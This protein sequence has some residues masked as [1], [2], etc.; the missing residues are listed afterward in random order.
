MSERSR[1][2]A[3]I[4]RYDPEGLLAIGAPADEYDPEAGDLLVLVHGTARIT[5]EA[6]SRVWLR[7]FG[8]S[9]WPESRPDQVAALAA[10]LEAMRRSCGG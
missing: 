3:L 8:G 2:R 6:V 1:V 10:E 4:G 7:W 9:A 5:P